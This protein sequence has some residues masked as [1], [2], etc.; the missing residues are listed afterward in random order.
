MYVIFLLINF[1]SIA[2]KY[3]RRQIQIARI[4]MSKSG[5]NIFIAM[6]PCESLVKS[7]EPFSEKCI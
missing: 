2:T 5:F 1:I 4:F 6:D 7:K 3:E